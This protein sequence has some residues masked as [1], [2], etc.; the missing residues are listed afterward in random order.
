MVV[1]RYGSCMS[2][3]VLVLC[4]LREKFEL[5]VVSWDGEARKHE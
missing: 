1:L 3:K 2:V 4:W 5:G